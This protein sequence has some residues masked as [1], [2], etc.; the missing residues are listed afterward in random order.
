MTQLGEAVAVSSFSLNEEECPM[1]P[2]TKDDELVGKNPGVK[3]VSELRSSMESGKSTREWI[4]N[5][6]NFSKGENTDS[7]IKKTEPSFD[8]EPILI[9]IKSYPLSIAAHHINPRKE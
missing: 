9:A 5:N 6:G 7:G 3:K 8:K 2:Y 1:M 4:G